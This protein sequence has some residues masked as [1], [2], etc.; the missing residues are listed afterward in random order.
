LPTGTGK[1]LL[2][3]TWLLQHRADRP[4]ADPPPLV[5]IVLPFLSIIDQTTK[6]YQGLLK[7]LGLDPGDL[8]SYHSLSDRTYDTSLDDKSQEFFLDTWRSSVVITTFDQ[9]LMALLS[10]RGKHQM[11]F[12]HLTDAV[13]VLDEVQTLPP[14]LWTPLQAVLSELVRMGTT[15]IL[16]MSATQ[17]GF[18]P[19][20]SELIAAPEAFFNQMHRYK[21]VLRL[22]TSIRLTDFAAECVQRL[23]EW[24]MR[25]V[26]ITLNTR[27]SA[28]VIMDSLR[29]AGGAVEFLTADVTPADRLAAVERIKTCRSCVVVS[30]QCIEAGVDIDMDLV[31][32]DFGPLDS[33][34]Q[35][36]GRCNRNGALERGTVEVVQLKEDDQPTEFA[37]YIYDDVLRFATGEVLAGRKEVMEEEVFPLTK[38]YFLKLWEKKNTGEDVLRAWASWEETE[39]TKRL[40]RGIEPPKV[41]F[42]VI[43]KDTEL[44][45]DLE[46]AQG[47]EDRW[48]KRRAFRRLAARV[49][50]L[51]V[52]VYLRDGFDPSR[53]GEPFPPGKTAREAW[54][55]L[56]KPGYYTSDRG[57]DLGAAAEEAEGWGAII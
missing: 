20:N 26:L 50:L 49:S 41:A 5:L 55:W 40:L 23:P 7:G 51:T 42:V 34:I 35:V 17:P 53:Y 16:A 12:H 56:L 36:A 27:R 33:L 24:G 44:L 4:A 6:E 10:P 9:F 15:R 25:K 22:G 11:R 39:S 48:E 38:Q 18:L 54:F 47:V 57:L 19:N 8:I 14:R 43:E 46:T 52:S 29:K 1:T 21:I 28:R 30:T 13:I 3:A 31:I 2:A 45:H 37:S 32:R